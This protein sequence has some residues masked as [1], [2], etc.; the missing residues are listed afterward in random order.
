MNKVKQCK[1]CKEAWLETDMHSA[2]GLCP[3]CYDYVVSLETKLVEK[4]KEIVYM[5]D[6]ANKLN[7][8]VQKYFDVK[9]ILA[10]KDQKIT[11]LEANLENQNEKYYKLYGY[12]I[13]KLSEYLEDKY[14]LAKEN[15]QLK[16]VCKNIDNQIKQLT[17]DKGE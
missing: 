6:Q 13:D 12:Y 3:N 7:N 8:E 9:K 15:E 4:E 16:Q 14:R 17:S 10:E 1:C 2:I 5:A 11:D